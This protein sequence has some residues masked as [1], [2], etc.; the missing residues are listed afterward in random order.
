MS[1]IPPPPP[2]GR[3]RTLS[4]GA[5]VQLRH[6]LGRAARCAQ[7]QHMVR[8]EGMALVDLCGAMLGDGAAKADVQTHLQVRVTT[9][10]REKKR[11]RWEYDVF[12]FRTSMPKVSEVYSVRM[13]AT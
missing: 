8:E 11:V 2:P 13:M 4:N 1:D 3:Y 5:S 6:M 10:P 7:R 12:L 9:F